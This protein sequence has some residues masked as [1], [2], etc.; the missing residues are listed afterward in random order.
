MAELNRL[1]PSHLSLLVSASLLVA[2]PLSSQDASKLPFPTAVAVDST[3]AMYLAGST[4]AAG[5]STTTGVFQPSLPANACISQ[6]AH[7]F[8]AKIA[9]GVESAAWAS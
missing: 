2:L 7:G 4:P 8:I 9:P 6:C 1:R 3:G 5:L